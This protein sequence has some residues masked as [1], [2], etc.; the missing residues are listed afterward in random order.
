MKNILV[1]DDEI[2]ICNNIK[3]IL[4]DE[5]F[6]VQIAHHSDDAFNYINSNSYNLIILDVWLDNSKHDGLELLKKIRK[7]I[8]LL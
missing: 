3:A 5:G 4:V 6:D 1:I 8:I 7:N 2:D